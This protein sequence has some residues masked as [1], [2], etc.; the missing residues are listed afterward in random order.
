MEAAPTLETVVQAVQTLYH[1]PDLSAKEK[2]SKW[3]GDLQRSVHAWQM[4]DQL[5]RLSQNVESSYFAAQT[6]R[7]KIQ[8]AF[9][10][11]PADSHASLRDS[12]IAHIEQLSAE[13]SPVILTQLCLAL[14]DLALQMVMWKNSVQDLLQ[15]FGND[16]KYLS[17]LLEVLTVIP[18]EINSRTLRLGANRRE[19][20]IQE[21][22]QS[23]SMVI[24]LL[25]NC[26]DTTNDSRLLTK[27][28]KCLASWFN[29]GVIPDDLISQSKVMKAPFHVLLNRETPSG[30]HEAATDCICAALYVAEDLSKH[31]PLAELLSQG[32]MM[33]QEPYHMSVA[34]EDIDKSINFCRIFTE[35]AESFL[36]IMVKMPGKG[37]GQL[38]ILDFLLTC[39]GHHQYEV[40]EITFNFWYRISETLYKQDNQEHSDLFRPYIQRLITA[41]CFH[42]QMDPDH[43]GI[44][45]EKDDFGD[46]RIRVS[47][48]IKDVV[49]LV[50]SSTCFKQMFEALAAQGP[51]TSWETTEAALFVMSAVAKN[52]LPN[53]SE[54][55][56]HVI[57]AI[58]NLPNDAH[59]AVR[60]TSTHLIGELGEWIEQH[61]EY[62]DPTLGFLMKGLQTSELGSAAA[63][64]IQCICDVLSDHMTNHF[65]GLLQITQAIDS[66][67]LSHDAAIGLIKGAVVILAKQPFEKVTEGVKQLVTAQTHPLSQLVKTDGPR[68]GLNSDP[69]IWLDRLSAIFRYANPSISNGQLHPCQPALMEIWPILSQIMGKYQTDERIIERCCRCLRFA[70]RSVGKGAVALLEPLVTQMVVIYQVHQHSCFLYLGSILVDEY[71][72]E[73][74]CVPG[75][76]D[77]LQALSVPTFQLL[78]K[79][80]GFR[81]HPDTIDDLYRLAA[82][83]LQRCPVSFLQSQVVVPILQCALAATSLEHRDAN[84]SVMKFFRDLIYSSTGHEDRDDYEVRKSAVQSAI[85]EHGQQL[86]NNLI[87][88]VVFHLPVY[89]V[90]EIGDVIY[91]MMV[92]DRPSVCRWLEAALKSLPTET[93]PGS[94]SAT[95]KQLIDFHKKVTSAEDQNQVSYALRDFARLFR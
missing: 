79:E 40:A 67:N 82:R 7:T 69:A 92:F 49:F 68:D 83:F 33:L 59:I 57:K 88:A 12:L 27:V 53:E 51:N 55:V 38:A 8:Y 66:F 62:L 3:L 14:A 24:T 72:R 1:S 93:K 11:L 21:F 50:G 84:A 22:S 47:E 39:V 20:I 60:Y 78:Q 15:R 56:P 34:E 2:A 28:F 61:T 58:I 77:M 71:G 5:M 54:V 37:L 94:I 4:A 70:I 36:E 44:P 86:I 32:V 31:Y 75:L 91:E 16:P 46:F 85:N 65:E 73:Q 63:H 81:D 13:A 43:E 10:E 19:E 35:L 52:V 30:L 25:T 87:V 23:V 9:H 48:L 6:M 41:L 45:D 89:M 26:I 76:L 17:F 29:V 64:A 90:P 80:N 18:E 42:C 74:G 95:H